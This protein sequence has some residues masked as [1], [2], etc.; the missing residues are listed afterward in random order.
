VY[1]SYSQGFRSGFPQS[2]LVLVVAPDFVPVKPD[3]LT[4]YEIGAKGSLFDNR[5]SFET[6][7]YFM[8][9][10]DIQQTLGILIAG[11]TAGIVANVNG[12][13][14][15][16][17]GVDFAI[18]ARPIPRLLF[19][20][21]FG[22]NGLSE[23]ATVLSGGQ[24]LFPKGARLD[25]SPAYT[26]GANASYDFPFGS[27]GWSGQVAAMLR[28]TSLQTATTVS[29]GSGL[30]PLVL[31]SD[32]IT[33]GRVS[34]ALTAP[35]HWRMMLYSDNV[36]NNRGITEPSTTPYSNISQRPRTTGLQLDY[37]YR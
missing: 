17:L 3:K 35:S 12:Q 4:N 23:D 26:A 22:W 14:A 11:T 21:N 27:T 8:K 5:L 9:W 31:E 36:A 6:A 28:Y 20:I 30:P 1:A 32:T 19:G 18:T 37:H 24:V 10:K 2:E 34:F 25:S 13:S 33:T 29:S 7:V 15:S 16:G